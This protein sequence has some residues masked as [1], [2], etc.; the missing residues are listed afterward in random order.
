MCE[1]VNEL[2][3]VVETEPYQPPASLSFVLQD[4]LS[5]RLSVYRVNRHINTYTHKVQ[6]DD[7]Y[8]HNNVL[9]WQYIQFIYII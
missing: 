3:K 6:H 8:T 5:G 1:C 2:I 7:N 4:L 9:L